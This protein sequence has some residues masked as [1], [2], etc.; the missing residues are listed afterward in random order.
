MYLNIDKSQVGYWCT[1]WTLQGLSQMGMWLQPR[2]E[3]HLLVSE[4]RFKL[5]E[6][7]DKLE[8]A[9][10]TGPDLSRIE[11]LVT[12]FFIMNKTLPLKKRNM[13]TWSSST[14]LLFTVKKKKILTSILG[15]LHIQP[16]YIYICGPSNSR[17]HFS[18]IYALFM[19]NILCV[20]T[21]RMLLGSQWYGRA[22]LCVGPYVF[23]R[24][25]IRSRSQIK[26]T[27]HTVNVYIVGYKSNERECNAY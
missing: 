12:S 26:I 18:I 7:F 19:A 1:R 13:N 20:L 5:V 11:L 24:K 10:G 16:F 21:P 22:H 17:G 15:Y 8:T 6:L 23:C 2:L 14:G 4:K 9:T 27:G 3:Q 25:A